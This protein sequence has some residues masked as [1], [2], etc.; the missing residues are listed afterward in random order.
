MFTA[1][2][3]AIGKIWKQLK[4]PQTD[5]RAKKYTMECYSATKKEGNNAIC[6]NMDGPRDYFSK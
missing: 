3:L 5:E 4:C 6:N 2:L 1:A